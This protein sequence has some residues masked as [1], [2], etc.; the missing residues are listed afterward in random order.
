MDPSHVALMDIVWPNTTFDVYECDSS[1]KFGVR[2]DEFLKLMRR[3]DKKDIVE[4]SVGDDS[5]LCISKY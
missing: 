3:A 1:I 4:V 5:M 2:V